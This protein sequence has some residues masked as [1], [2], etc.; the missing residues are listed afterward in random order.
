MRALWDMVRVVLLPN[1]RRGSRFGKEIVA[2]VEDVRASGLPVGSVLPATLFVRPAGEVNVVSAALR[3][4]FA[5]TGVEFYLAALRGLNHW[6]ELSHPIHGRPTAFPAVPADLLREV[7]AAVAARRP[8]VL[9]LALQASIFIL[10]RLRGAAD[11]RFRD[12][13]LDGLDYLFTEAVYSETRSGTRV[14]EYHEVPAIRAEAAELA[15]A[16]SDLGDGR[17]DVVRHWLEAA[18]TDPLPE[19]RRAAERTLDTDED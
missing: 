16:L 12:S 17:H 8:G 13:L 9:R 1:A 15:K 4:E 5:H 19:V 7:G 10:K 3:R 2:F 18:R 14:V 6:A 11:R